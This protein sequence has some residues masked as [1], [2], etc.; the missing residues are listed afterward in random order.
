[1][2]AIVYEAYGSPHDVLRIR[3]IETPAVAE[4]E[5]LVRVR[6]VSPNPY[7]WHYMRGLPYLIRLVNG[8]RKPRRPTVIG[9]DVAGTVEKVGKGATRFKLGDE[10]FAEVGFGGCADYINVPEEKLEIKPANLTFDQAAAI[11]M[12]AQTALIGMRDKGA[13]QPGHRVLVNG[14][15]GGVGTFAV[16]LAKV[17]GAEVT[18]VC[19]ARNE[20]LV[21]SI[22]ADH[23][24]DYTK[25]D[26][27]QYSERY[28]FVLDV[29]GNH[30]LRKCRRVLKPKGR[31]GAVGGGDGRVLG[32]ASQ[33]L[34]ATLLSPFVS[35][36][37][38]PV[39]DKP[40]QDLRYLK[41]LAETEKLTPVIG[42]T[43]CFEE[44]ATAIEHLETGH[45][46][47]KLTIAID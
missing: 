36:K 23:V 6:S 5:V 10:V 3:D 39:N 15:S 38:L 19:N 26:F 16:Q 27:T 37:M 8:L 41:D 44:T 30:P 32:P 28:D 47:G 14:A 45:V 31:Y 43:Y 20:E 24:I 17:R 1:M 22:G 18:A 2:K 42:R 21:R 12:A 4:D 33:Q 11:P 7:D 9:S 40:N 46:R 35:Q 29:V 13:V 34:R 25:E